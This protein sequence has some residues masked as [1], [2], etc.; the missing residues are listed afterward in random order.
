[1]SIGVQVR[2]FQDL[3]SASGTP[4]GFFTL[5]GEDFTAADLQQGLT[6]SD[7]QAILH[8]PFG[9]RTAGGNPRATHFKECFSLMVQSQTEWHRQFCVLPKS[10]ESLSPAKAE[11]AIR[12]FLLAHPG[13]RP[14]EHSV[15]R[16]MAGMIA[17]FLDCKEA[18]GYLHHD[19]VF[20]L[21]IFAKDIE[22]STNLRAREDIYN[23]SRGLASLLL[24]DDPSP[25]AFQRRL[26]S[27]RFE[28]QDALTRDLFF[29]NAGIDPGPIR[30]I[31]ISVKSPY[32]T[33]VQYL[34]P[35]STALGRAQYRS[36]ITVYQACH[37]TNNWPIFAGGETC[38]ALPSNCRDEI[39]NNP[40]CRR[41]G[42]NIKALADD[43]TDQALRTNHPEKQHSQ[44]TQRLLAGV[45]ELRKQDADS[46]S[47]TKSAPDAVAP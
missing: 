18:G 6:W 44:A 25:V 40:V 26:L 33:T 34:D 38:I 23:P 37:R 19:P 4:E 32:L 41:F 5:T 10:H 8:N 12:E 16:Q 45:H 1:M 29:L 15:Y 7:V 36:A 2:S 21:G 46:A 35:A 9:W 27:T 28:I 11:P 47:T 31:Q 20:G 24:V 42:I 39:A 30:F 13:Q 14:I 22:T 17:S 3:G 43:A